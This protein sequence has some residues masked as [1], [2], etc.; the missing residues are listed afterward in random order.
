MV[1]LPLPSL[2]SRTRT[3]NPA[4]FCIALVEADFR[5]VEYAKLPGP[6][7]VYLFDGPHDAIDQY[8]GLK[9]ALPA[10]ADQFVFIVDDWNWARVRDGTLAAIPRCDLTV[11]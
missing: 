6:F 5:Y 4:A 1:F 11:L 10:L 3:T 2:A 7:P 9:L 8:Y